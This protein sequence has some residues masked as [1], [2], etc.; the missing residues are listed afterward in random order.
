MPATTASAFATDAGTDLV[1]AFYRAILQ[2]DP[3]TREQEMALFTSQSSMRWRLVVGKGDPQ[4]AQDVEP[5]KRTA[6][7]RA[8]R[9]RQEEKVNA[10][11]PVV[12]AWFREHRDRFL[13]KNMRSPGD[14]QVSS[15]YRFVRDLERP[16]SPAKAGRG[17]VMALFTDDTNAPPDK[18]RFRTIVFRLEGGKINPDAVYLDGYGGR[19]ASELLFAEGE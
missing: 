17:S 8:R 13:P 5:M 12:L 14:I 7:Q 3:P 11:G 4:D 16:K 10:A 2:K 19:T 1:V 15:T 6:E 18:M 9:R